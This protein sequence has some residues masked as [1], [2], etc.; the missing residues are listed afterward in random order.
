MAHKN[1][2]TL[3]N[4]QS[5]ASSETTYT[6]LYDSETLDFC[7]EHSASICHYFFLETEAR[8]KKKMFSALCPGFLVLFV[9]VLFVFIFL[10]SKT[11]PSLLKKKKSKT[12]AYSINSLVCSLL[13]FLQRIHNP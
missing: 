6:L 12:E 11:I 1:Y 2:W 8:N 4:N 5:R 3:I 9:W 7:S 13:G 10:F